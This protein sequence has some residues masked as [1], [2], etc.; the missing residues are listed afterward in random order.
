MVSILFDGCVGPE[1]ITDTR[2]SQTRGYHRPEGI[3]DTGSS[4]TF[5]STHPAVSSKPHGPAGGRGGPT[6]DSRRGGRSSLLGDASTNHKS[7]LLKDS[8]TGRSNHTGVVENGPTC[9]I[10]AFVS[11]SGQEKTSVCGSNIAAPNHVISS[12]EGGG[13]SASPASRS[14]DPHHVGPGSEGGGGGSV[15]WSRTMHPPGVEGGG[16][17]LSSIRNV[18]KTGLNSVEGGVGGSARSRDVFTTRGNSI[19][20]QIVFSASGTRQRKSPFLVK[21]ESRSN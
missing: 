8:S 16:N 9:R 17:G 4:R 11:D 3:T 14:K 20:V 21:L 12:A 6:A 7:S 2:V 15:A 13:A 5:N 1:G 10:Y 18:Y 19:R